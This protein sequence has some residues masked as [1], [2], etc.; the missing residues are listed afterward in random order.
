[1]RSGPKLIETQ[2]V[3]TIK[4][5]MGRAVKV[6]GMFALINDS[7]EGKTYPLEYIV[8]SQQSTTLPIAQVLS[9]LQVKPT[10]SMA[11][12]SAFSQAHGRFH[13]PPTRE[14]EAWLEHQ[15]EEA[16]RDELGGRIGQYA[17]ITMPDMA[18]DLRLSRYRIPGEKLYG[19]IQ[20]R[21]PVDGVANAPDLPMRLA[22]GLP[23]EDDPPFIILL[24]NRET[25]TDRA[26]EKDMVKAITG[27]IPRRMT[28]QNR[29]LL[30]EVCEQVRIVII[31]DEACRAP[32]RRLHYLR[33]LHDR[34]R[35]PIIFAGT[36]E[37]LRRL[38]TDPDLGPLKTRMRLHEKISPPTKEELREA[39]PHLSEAVVN[40]LWEQSDHT[41]R[42][43]AYLLEYLEDALADNPQLKPSV[44]LVDSC[45]QLLFGERLNYAPS[46]LKR[47]N[48]PN[49]VERERIVVN[50]LREHT[51]SGEVPPA[52]A[53]S[54]RPRK[55]ATS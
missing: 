32:N 33:E 40:R 5:L 21:R 23:R 4:W 19:M 48:A 35:I 29:Q 52:R 53:A 39:L 55:R 43:F 7:G 24:R 30:E 49:P 3:R 18:Y 31:F 44:G 50:D 37:L 8:R 42:T 15:W 12:A 34:Y 20:A 11:E 26:I 28:D 27:K 25:P 1:M 46:R 38:V 54:G 16:F 10:Y 2:G 51:N 17:F 6:P 13:S 41:F 9:N 36:S 14:E 22:L 47:A 45:V